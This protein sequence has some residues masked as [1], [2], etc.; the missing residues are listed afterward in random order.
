MCAVGWRGHDCH[1]LI[2]IDVEQQGLSKFRLLSAM[3]C[4]LK[5]PFYCCLAAYILKLVPECQDH[6]IAT[7]SSTGYWTLKLHQKSLL[8]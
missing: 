4:P 1:G 6:E 3:W 7:C 8:A 5:C 2:I